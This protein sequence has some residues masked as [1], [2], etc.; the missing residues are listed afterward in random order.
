[1]K[2]IAWNVYIILILLA[3]GSA[4]AE[5]DFQYWSRFSFT[6]IKTEKLSYTNFSELRIREDSSN[7]GLWYTSQRFKVTP[8]KYAEFGINYTYL[9]SEVDL[10]K[11]RGNEWKFQH[12]LE[13][14]V[15]PKWT[16]DNGFL[17][18]NR[19]RLEFRWIEDK[20]SDNARLR[21]LWE[22][23]IPIKKFEWLKSIFLNNEYFID[24]SRQTINENRVIPIGLNFKLPGGVSLQ[25][26]YMIQSQKGKD[27]RSNQI[28][29]TKWSFSF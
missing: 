9:E 6:P 5:D 28:V 15:N 17:L 18:K 14:E 2:R 26:F 21:Q 19:N 1:M 13:L 20:G 3:A 27:W 22:L 25:T 12:R 7:L 29:G 23:D 10:S 24:F 8:L 4:R 11:G 16:F